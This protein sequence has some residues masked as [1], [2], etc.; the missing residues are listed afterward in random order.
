[1][2]SIRS[3]GYCKIAVTPLLTHWSYC[4]LALNHRYDLA[5][6]FTT[7]IPLPGKR[8]GHNTET[9]PRS[10]HGGMLT[11]SR[12][13]WISYTRREFPLMPMPYKASLIAS[14]KAGSPDANT[15]PSWTAIIS[16][17][18]RNNVGGAGGS[19]E[20]RRSARDTSSWNRKDR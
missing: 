13:V 2:D 9:R 19:G 10:H 7:G 16:I 14:E 20:P 18:A 4:S 12:P 5:T 8:K 17:I 11:I 6:L 1:M 15:E 3:M